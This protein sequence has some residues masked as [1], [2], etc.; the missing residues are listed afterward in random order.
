MWFHSKQCH[1][2]SPCTPNMGHDE[3]HA[4][5]KL[6]TYEN[7][8]G[9]FSWVHCSI[10]TCKNWSSARIFNWILTEQQ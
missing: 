1:I 4:H 5:S 10:D 2:K 6:R 7:E 3:D 9:N 8:N